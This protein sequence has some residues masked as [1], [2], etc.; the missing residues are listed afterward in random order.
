M[1][2]MD[3]PKGK[4]PYMFLIYA[5]FNFS[6]WYL[7]LCISTHVIM[8]TVSHFTCTFTSKE[9]GFINLLIGKCFK[10]N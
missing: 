5:S 8:Q 7:V 1:N 3:I 9:R 10:A 6:W 2:I 4:L